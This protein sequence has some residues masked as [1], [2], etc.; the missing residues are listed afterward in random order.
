ML[1]LYYT[2]KMSL[3]FKDR[4]KIVLNCKYY[5]IVRHSTFKIERIIWRNIALFL[6][7]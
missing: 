7:I 3:N 2:L 4:E 6:D 1:L 5:N